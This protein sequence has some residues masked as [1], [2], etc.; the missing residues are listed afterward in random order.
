[1]SR[2]EIDRAVSMSS[3]GE[4]DAWL[5]AHGGTGRDVVIALYEARSGKRTVTLE[6]LQETVPCP[7]WVGHAEQADR[8]RALRDPL[9]SATTGSTWG[10]R[11]R[12]MA[13][14]CSKRAG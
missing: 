1:M 10:P 9:L 6:A 4:F 3:A 11:H 8:R 14:G 13:G 5:D 7:R 12:R 2:L